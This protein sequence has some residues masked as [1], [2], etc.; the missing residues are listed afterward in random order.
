MEVSPLA[1]VDVPKQSVRK[2]AVPKDVVRRAGI[3]EANSTPLLRT[4][5]EVQNP[6]EL[7]ARIVSFHNDDRKW[8]RIEVSWWS[9][10][11]TLSHIQRTLNKNNHISAKGSPLG[12]L[13]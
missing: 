10:F 7:A 13:R 12:L 4:T 9:S 8:G 1:E 2:P 11:K 3:I 6:S 5:T